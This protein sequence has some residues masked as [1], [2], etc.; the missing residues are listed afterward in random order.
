MN[1]SYSLVLLNGTGH[2][3]SIEEWASQAQEETR[4][5]CTIC[6]EHVF[7]RYG[8]DSMPSLFVIE[9]SN[10]ELDI[11][12]LIDIQLQNNQH[13]LRLAGVVYYGQHHFAAKL[14]YLMDRFGFT[15]ELL[16]EEI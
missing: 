1:D 15:M 5:M 10:Q 8:F 4:H 3:D 7:I 16:Q 13:R 2:Y 6:N 11:N 9:F 14:F 12:L